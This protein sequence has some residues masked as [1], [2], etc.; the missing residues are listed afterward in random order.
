MTPMLIVSA[1]GDA[2]VTERPCF[3]DSQR[4]EP[5]EPPIDGEDFSRLTENLQRSA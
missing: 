1:G 5:Q 2:G 4:T 3:R